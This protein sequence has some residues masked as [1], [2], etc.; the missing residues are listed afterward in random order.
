[1]GEIDKEDEAEKEKEHGTDEGEIVAPDEEEAFGDKESDDNQ[2]KPGDDLG[3][4]VPVL[5]SSS[6]I[7]GVVDTNKDDGQDSME[8]AKRKL[9]TVDSDEAVA[10][11]AEAGYRKVVE[12]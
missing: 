6:S 12:G 4:P 8:D 5:N 7:T 2:E 11:F 9:D 1:M 10:L 3:S